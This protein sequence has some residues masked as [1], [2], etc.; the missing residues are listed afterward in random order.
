MPLDGDYLKSIRITPFAKTA[1]EAQIK[2][3]PGRMEVRMVASGEAEATMGA[4]LE[5]IVGLQEPRPGLGHENPDSAL[6]LSDREGLIVVSE[7]IRALAH[8][9][10]GSDSPALDAV[11]AFWDYILGTLIFG[12]VHYDQI[13]FALPCDW[14]LDSGWFDCQLGAALF[15]ALCRARG[16]PARVISGYLLY[17]V[18]PMKHYWAEA[19]IEGQ[20]WTPFDFI[21]WDLSLGGRD[22]EWRDRYFG[23]LDY[24]LISER[25]PREFTGALGV[26]VPEAW[27]MLQ[28]ARDGGV[29]NNFMDVGGKPVY[30]DT[31]RVI[32]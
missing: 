2:L 28:S 23:R 7:R 21:S 25:M 29:A 6:Y 19:W 18:A 13:D 31:I 9:L 27:C 4:T 3:S 14:I 1:G 17:R 30:A 15:V 20:G 26:P 8:T 11:R 5:F 10:A 16:I 22:V 24:R 12:C 32:E